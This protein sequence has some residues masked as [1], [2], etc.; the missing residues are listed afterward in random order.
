MIV[1]ENTGRLMPG[2]GGVM[3]CIRQLRQRGSF[4]REGNKDI[5][6]HYNPELF[7]DV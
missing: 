5:C 6:Y 3:V 7:S 1:D 2:R 4:H